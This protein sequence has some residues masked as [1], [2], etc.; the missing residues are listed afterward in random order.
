MTLICTYFKME[1][2]A[3]KILID[4]FFFLISIIRKTFHGKYFDQKNRW[5]YE[6]R[7]CKQS[8]KKVKTATSSCSVT[9]IFVQCIYFVA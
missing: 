1:T 9:D 2:D 7:F 3:A 5:E 8:S 6:V 4:D